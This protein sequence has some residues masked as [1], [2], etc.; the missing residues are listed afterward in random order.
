MLSQQIEMGFLKQVLQIQVTCTY[1]WSAF[2]ILGES[3]CCL[4]FDKN[5]IFF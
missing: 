2:A 4:L 3:F 5:V 1:V